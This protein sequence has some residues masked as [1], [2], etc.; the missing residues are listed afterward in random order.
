[1]GT[2][3]RWRFCLQ[4]RNKNKPE[5]DFSR[6]KRF[7][8]TASLEARSSWSS[9]KLWNRKRYLPTWLL[10]FCN[11]KH[12]KQREYNSKKILLQRLKRRAAPLKCFLFLCVSF[13][14]IYDMSKNYNMLI[15]LWRLREDFREK[16]K[17]KSS[18]EAFKTWRKRFTNFRAEGVW[19]RIYSIAC[20]NIQKGSGS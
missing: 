6:C 14:G 13:A 10:Y 2:K 12:K 20:K 4:W 3:K 7:C 8:K 5:W 17:E 18:E 15:R 9:D 11:H 16:L 1:M 19:N